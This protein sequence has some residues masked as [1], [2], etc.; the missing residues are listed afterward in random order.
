MA[1]LRTAVHYPYVSGACSGPDGS[2]GRGQPD[3]PSRSPAIPSVKARPPA[4]HQREVA[5]GQNPKMVRKLY[6]F[7]PVARITSTAITA[8]LRRRIHLTMVLAIL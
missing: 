4:V 3:F 1:G 8:D 2:R 7:H 6:Q 5:E